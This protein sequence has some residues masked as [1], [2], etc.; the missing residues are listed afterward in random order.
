MPLL[1]PFRHA[2]LFAIFAMFHDYFDFRH[3]IID[4]AAF[5]HYYYWYCADC[6]IILR[7]FRLAL[8][9]I[10]PLISPFHCFH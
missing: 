3:F 6:F 2:L 10:T 1:M 5:L 9:A 7:H 4:Y 8:F